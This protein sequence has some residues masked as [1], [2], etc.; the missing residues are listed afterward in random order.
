VAELSDKERR[1]LNMLARHANGCEETALMVGG[2][3]VGH[4]TGLVLDGF[5][6]K[7]A[8]LTSVDGKGKF[9]IWLKITA[10]G[11]KAIVDY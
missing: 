6:T 5:V 3:T 7:R 1:V 8:S 9:S 4:L 11:R 10:A 2:V